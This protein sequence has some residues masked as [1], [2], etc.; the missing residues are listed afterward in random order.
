MEEVITLD[1]EP[2]VDASAAVDRGDN[3]DAETAE[4][5][6]LDIGALKAVAQEA[7]A[8]EEHAD[9]AESRIPKAR[10]DEV[11]ARMKQAETERAALQE[12]LRAL[13]APKEQAAQQEPGQVDLDAAEDAYL[14]A[15][16]DGDATRA[17]QIRG[18]INQHIQQ[19]AEAAAVA[20]VSAVMDKRDTDASL[21]AVANE[22]IAKY[23]FL[24]AE[25]DQANEEAIAEVVEWRDYYASKGLRPD[26]ALQKAVAKIVPMYAPKGKE[27]EPE[28]KTDSRGKEALQRNALAAAAQPMALNGVGERA[29]RARYD[30]AKMS[31]EEFDALPASERKRLRGDA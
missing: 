9:K 6:P 25:S 5:T 27:P 31:E 7:P 19:Q 4:E 23:P 10:F 29:S 21:V 18:A 1:A 14:Q 3:F 17:K 22:S 15:L 16:R 11:N 30:V 26:L 8:A 13:Q 12:Q 20:R 28:P 24:N 2:E